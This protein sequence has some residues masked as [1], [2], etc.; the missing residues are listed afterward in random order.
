M[1]KTAITSIY[2]YIKNTKI[3]GKGKTSICFL[4]S[5]NRVL[6]LFLNTYYKKRL[7]K[8]NDNIINHFEKINSLKNDSY[9]VSE[10]LLIKDKELIGYIYPYINGKT[11]HSIDKKTNIELLINSYDKLKEDTVLIS[12]KK[13]VLNDMHDRNIL[14]NYNYYIIDLD[15]GFFKDNDDSNKILNYN[16]YKINNTI[17][18]SLFNKYQDTIIEFIDNDLN[19][20]YKESIISNYNSIKLLLS[21]LSKYNNTKNDLI[22]KEK[23]LIKVYK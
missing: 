13:F 10:E 15:F 16:M 23:E 12:N 7:F 14:F 4:M 21:E 17:I 2:P 3:I 19:N 11:L 20:L 18:H 22:L 1:K 6:K 5:D 8:S 9:I